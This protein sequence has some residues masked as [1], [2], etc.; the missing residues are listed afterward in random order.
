MGPGFRRGD[1]ERLEPSVTLYAIF[2]PK[3][4]RLD[5][6]AAV[7]EKFCWFAAILPPVFLLAHGLWLELV[8]WILA[9]LVLVVLSGFIGDGAA[10]LLYFLAALWLGFAA[11]GL[12][13]HALHWRGW[14]HRGERV[15]L[16]ADM[17]Q[18]EAMR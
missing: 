9:V 4:G 12:R 5:L 10:S 17:A 1:I 18:L 6:P 7:P 16:S 2:D 15:A 8:A 14:A 11:P 13:R 3:P